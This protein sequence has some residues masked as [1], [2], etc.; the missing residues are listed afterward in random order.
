[1]SAP[2]DTDLVLRPA[3]WLAGVRAGKTPLSRYFGFMHSGD[4]YAGRISA[5]WKAMGLAG[6]GPLTSAYA[7][8]WAY[9]L[10]GAAGLTVSGPAVK[11]SGAGCRG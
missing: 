5:G 2:P 11:D 4:P 3:T 9:L 1:M 8:V 10:Q 6:F 7:A